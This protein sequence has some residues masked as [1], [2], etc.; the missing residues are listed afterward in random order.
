MKTACSL[1]TVVAQIPDGAMLMIG[2]FLG[3]GTPHRLIQGLVTAGRTGLTVITN[4]THY[5][6]IGIGRLIEARLVKRLITTHIGTNPE[7]QRQMMAG[8]IN[9]ELV[10]Q[11]TLAERIRAGGHGLGGVLTSMGVGTLVDKDK[12]HI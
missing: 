9:V 7:T 3:V 5:P 10:P 1:E 12:H 8:E 4:D 11:G 6:G 2:G